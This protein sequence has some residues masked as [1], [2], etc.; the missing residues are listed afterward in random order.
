M[1]IFIEFE[2]DKK[3]AYFLTMKSD[4]TRSELMS[5]LERN[6]YGTAGRLLIARSKKHRL[7]PRKN[8]LKFQMAA[9]FSLS[10]SFSAEKLG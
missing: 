1:R 4:L 8:R 5:I 10:P 6:D 7:V 3:S 9:D 2:H